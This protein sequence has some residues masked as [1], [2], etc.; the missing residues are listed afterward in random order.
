MVSFAGFVCGLD[1]YDDTWLMRTLICSA[2]KSEKHY[3]ERLKE[4][5]A[6]MGI[7]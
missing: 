2:T 1:E 3:K 7:D 4:L 5:K 6:E